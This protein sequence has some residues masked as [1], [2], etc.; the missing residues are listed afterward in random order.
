MKNEAD[1]LNE[2]SVEELREELRRR[3]TSI[4]GLQQQVSHLTE[5]LD[6]FKRQL[7]GKKSE[8]FMDINP[9]QPALGDLLDGVPESPEEPVKTK[10]VTCPVKRRRR[11]EGDDGI[12]MPDDLPIVEKVHELDPEEA[13]CL[14]TGEPLKII[15]YEISDKLAIKPP[16]FYILRHKRAKYASA[17]DPG[18]GV[19]TAPMP[20]A[21]IERSSAD[22]SLLA[23]FLICK[24]MDHLPL[25]RLSQ[26]FSRSGIHI[27]RKTMS[28]WAMQLGDVLAAVY[29]EMKKQVL[30][31]PSLFIDETTTKELNIGKCAIRYIWVAVGGGGGGGDPPYRIYHFGTRQHEQLDRFIGDYSGAVHSDQYKAYLKKA[32]ADDFIWQ[33]CGAHARRKFEE[34][35]GFSDGFREWILRQF[36]R[37]FLYERVAWKQNPEQRLVIRREKEEPIID[38]IIRRCKEELV[39]KTHLPRSKSRKA[40][41]Y[42]L[43]NAPYMK[44]YIDNPDMRFDNNVAERALRPL[45]LGRKNWLF[46]GS[47]RGGRNAAIIYSILQT[48]KALGVNP[49]EYLEDVL[50]RIL[51]HNSN[52]VAELLPDRWAAARAAQSANIH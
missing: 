19:I 30:A 12:T 52:R 9:L 34:A 1:N 49:Q 28:A 16:Q 27:H 3:D 39:A 10:T 37:I 45:T 31:A 24:Y 36:R 2:V 41:E 44:N 18:Q 15:D 33:P 42:L 8:R 48:C 50:P 20:P 26:I 22:V 35:A 11:G 32:Q 40:L 4:I 21:P 38:E 29:E 17:S 25:N 7:F 46:V 5:Q 14:E 6:W 13:V 47:E 23:Y 43:T 51:D